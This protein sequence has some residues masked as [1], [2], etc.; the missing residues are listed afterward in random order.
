MSMIFSKSIKK[1]APFWYVGA[2]IIA[3]GSMLVPATAAP[4]WFQQI[5][6]GYI[7]RGTFATS[8][9]I[10][11]MYARILPRGSKAMTTIMGLRAPLAIMAAMIIL[12][13]NGFYLMYYFGRVFTSGIAMDTYEI[14]AFIS[15][16]VMWILLL[17]LT[18]TSF[19]KVRRKMNPVKWKNL[20][21]W[22]YLFYALIYVHVCTLFTKQILSGHASYGRDLAIYTFV[23]GYYAVKRVS[24]ALEMKKKSNISQY[25]L[26]IGIPVVCIICTNMVYAPYLLNSESATAAITVNA[27]S[28]DNAAGSDGYNSDESTDD[29]DQNTASADTIDSNGNNNSNVN[30]NSSSTTNTDSN[31]AAT[32]GYIDGTYTGSSFGYNDDI[33]VSVTIEDSQITDINVVSSLEDDPYFT[34]VLQQI[35]DSIIES[36]STDVDTVTGATTSSKAYIHAVEAA[37]AQAQ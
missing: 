30:N 29:S 20:Q 1:H 26:K 14:I 17:P 12:L 24:L 35:P 3:L 16:T 11:V 18:I 32:S 13:H 33:T 36:Q 22:S 19:M 31:N 25:L 34:W 2:F 10:L 21:R 8:L 15:T 9:F 28:G 6:M 7:T 27:S 4:V 37:L 23:F 5:V